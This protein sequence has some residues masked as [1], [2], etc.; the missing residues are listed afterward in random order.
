METFKEFRTILLGHQLI[1]HTDHQNLTYKKFNSDRVLRW[2]LFI[3]EFAHDL[4]YIPGEKNVVADALSRLPMIL[5]NIQDTTENY[6]TVMECNTGDNENH[7]FHPLSYHHLD[8][9]QQVAPEIKKI[10]K[11][12]NSPYHLK[13][14]HGGGK[15]RSLVCH[16]DKIVVPTKLQKH[17]I[18]WYHTVLCHP[19]INRTEETIGQHLYWPKM[20]NQITAHVSACPTCQKSKRRIKKY[21]HLPPKEAEAEPWDKMCIDL[22]GP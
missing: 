7:E 11:E 9:A 19:G 21:G 8:Q 14:F 6:Y 5:N 16:K 17:V 1:V 4:Q 15:T 3:E 18:D 13:D 22:I 10:L 2:R 20:R 12:D